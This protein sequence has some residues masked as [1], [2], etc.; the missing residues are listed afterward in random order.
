MAN[1]LFEEN[2]V[3]A[4]AQAPY[5]ELDESR[6]NDHTITAVVANETNP[7][8]VHAP[9]EIN[10]GPVASDVQPA[11]LLLPPPCQSLIPDYS[12]NT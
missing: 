9:I 2:N 1:E 7:V 10:I 4:E 6:T 8:H 12:N 3:V 5:R 11:I